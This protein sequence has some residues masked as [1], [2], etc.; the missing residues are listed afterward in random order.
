[1]GKRC[2]LYIFNQN[3][4]DLDRFNQPDHV[5]ENDSGLI[6]GDGGVDSLIPIRVIV[7][8]ISDF[9]NTAVKYFDGLN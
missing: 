4:E 6:L 1:M 9:E 7:L 3:A 5:A 2:E 8:K